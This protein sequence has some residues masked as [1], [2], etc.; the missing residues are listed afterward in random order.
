MSLLMN[1]PTRHMIQMI[2]DVDTQLMH[3]MEIGLNNIFIFVRD[4]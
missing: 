1:V 3:F 4:Q 2:G